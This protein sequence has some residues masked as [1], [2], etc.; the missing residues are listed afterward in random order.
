[1]YL[2]IINLF[3]FFDKNYRLKILFL[4]ILLLIS[5]LFEILSIFSIGPL[6]QLLSNP[7]VINEPHQLVSKIYNYFNFKYFES[8]LVFV[9]SI[10][11]SFMFI[12]TLILTFTL[13]I[14]ST[15]SQTLGHIIRNS[16]FKFYISQDWIYHSKSNSSENLK[17]IGFEANRVIQNIIL[18]ILLTNSKVLTG[19]LIIISLT[20]F[21]PVASMICFTVFGFVYISIFKFIKF[22]ISSYGKIQSQSMNGMYKTMSET[23]NGIKEAIIYGKQYKYFKIFFGNSIR[24][25]NASGKISFYQNAPRH[26]LE[27][28]AISVILLFILFL[29]YLGTSNF[30]EILPV[31]SIYI[32]A[33]YKLLPIFQNIYGGLVQIRSS[34]PALVNIEKELYSSKNYLL[35]Q[36]SF[37]NDLVEIKNSSSIIF[38]DVSFFYE[39]HRKKAVKKINFEIKPNSL[40]Y[41]IGSSGSGKSTILDLILGLIYPQEGEISIGDKKLNEKNSK[42]WHKNFGYVG[43]NVFLL[44][45]T[46][47]NNI[48]FASEGESINE[49]NLK[50][51]LR[52]SNVEP[53]L[54]NLS[55]GLNTFVGERGIQLSGGQ[56]QR[57]SIARALYQDK[58]ILI[59]DEATSSLD[60]IAE[61]FITEQLKILSKKVTIIIVSHNVKL[62]KNA[63]SIN[64]L[65]DGSII[66]SGKYEDIKENDLFL[67]LLNEKD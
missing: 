27:F 28:F 4:Q 65:E 45:D 23:F 11:L 43:Q 39:D 44:D 25:T 63:D 15:F 58:K 19:I 24:F 56:R 48:C 55:N 67:K 37:K 5:S 14:L 13:Y 34:Y 22:R 31:L 32:F 46:I 26:I 21:H 9:V 66:A 38:K 64:L 62:C 12:S 29:S 8:F 2:K 49:E 7:D 3:K 59:F 57:V 10:I 60:G 61:K 18:P 51:A 35:D 47:K 42:Y 16:L 6:V 52:L 36:H 1:M 17:K 30:N 53:F 33:G 20:F 40:N 41:I 54:N 50:R